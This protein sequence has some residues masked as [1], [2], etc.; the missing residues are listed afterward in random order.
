MERHRD[1]GNIHSCRWIG[2]CHARKR[3]G[4]LP[5]RFTA[6]M[7]ASVPDGHLNVQRTLLVG[8]H[9]QEPWHRCRSCFLRR[10][11]IRCRMLH[12]VQMNSLTGEGSRRWVCR[13]LRGTGNDLRNG[14]LCRS[15]HQR[16]REVVI[17]LLACV[18]RRDDLQRSG[19]AGNRQ[20]AR[21]MRRSGDD[22]ISAIGM[23]S[24]NFSAGSRWVFTGSGLTRTFG[25]GLIPAARIIVP[26]WFTRQRGRATGMVGVAST[27][28][29]ATMYGC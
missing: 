21:H 7:M 26:H 5:Q 23:L 3:D 12:V 1:L 15:A 16:S 4:T 2:V 14:G 28:S 17:T 20:A 13:V 8:H 19:G 22:T 11:N 27:L 29:I 10:D 25:Q 18:H 9:I 24:L 6:H